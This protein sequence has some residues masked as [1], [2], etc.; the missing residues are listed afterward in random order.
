MHLGL[1]PLLLP[2]RCVSFLQKKLRASSIVLCIPSKVTA[3]N[4]CL[5]LTT[6]HTTYPSYLELKKM[7][8]HHFWLTKG[9]KRR[10]WNGRSQWRSQGPACRHLW[11]GCCCCH[12]L[13][14]TCVPC[15]ALCPILGYSLTIQSLGQGH[16]VGP[17]PILSVQ[18][19]WPRKK[20]YLVIWFYSGK[21]RLTLWG[22]K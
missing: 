13:W 14:Q 1:T 22:S 2:L 8:L 18:L 10:W 17:S 7:L 12:H 11:P 20:D 15:I 4:I 16:Q 19:S 3:V 5:F 9:M 21:P 6:K